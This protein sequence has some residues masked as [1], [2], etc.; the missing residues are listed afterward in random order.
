MVMHLIREKTFFAKTVD[1]VAISSVDDSLSNLHLAAGSSAFCSR[2][3]STLPSLSAFA[4]MYQVWFG[5][6][7]DHSRAHR[8]WLVEDAFKSCQHFSFLVLWGFV[9]PVVLFFLDPLLGMFQAKYALY[10]ESLARWVCAIVSGLVTPTT[11]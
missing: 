2:N 10:S 6:Y 5:Y 11:D 3:L 4:E 9:I 7:L 8:S 1:L